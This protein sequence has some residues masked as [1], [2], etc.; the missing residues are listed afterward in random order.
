MGVF[1]ALLPGTPALVEQRSA[2][3]LLRHRKRRAQEREHP[4]PEP[5]G[6]K[7]KVREELEETRDV[8]SLKGQ[9]AGMG[10][11]QGKGRHS[12]GRNMVCKGLEAD[13][14]TLVPL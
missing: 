14:G 6:G 11:R 13:E 5:R 3:K 1:R 10:R 9:G 8:L 12:G 7:F 2:W 4:T